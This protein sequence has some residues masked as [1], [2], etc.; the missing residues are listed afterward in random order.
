MWG[1]SSNPG[2]E[3]TRDKK[4]P[5]KVLRGHTKRQDRA[6]V[7]RG[8]GAEWWA[9][10]GRRQEGKDGQASRQDEGADKRG[11]KR[12]AVSSNSGPEC[13]L[14]TPP[15]KKGGGPLFAFCTLL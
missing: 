7:K 13:P 4:R 6:R 12:W 5:Y 1:A 2:S 10:Q 9:E 15:Q 11:D 3:R 14:P 8:H